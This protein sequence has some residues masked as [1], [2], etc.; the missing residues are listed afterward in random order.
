V[1]AGITVVNRRTGQPYDIYAG[2]PTL[3]GNPYAIGVD[4][5]RDEVVEQYE[6]YAWQRMHKDEK[7]RGLLL[8]CENRRVACWCAPL[9]CHVEAIARLI[10]RWQTEHSDVP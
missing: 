1:L 6:K 8:S 9:N 2:R 7:F 4:G 3:L 5:T 10:E